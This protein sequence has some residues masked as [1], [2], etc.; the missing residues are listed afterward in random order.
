[1]SEF[2]RIILN[3]IEHYGG[4]R[5]HNTLDDINSQF[6]KGKIKLFIKKVKCT[7]DPAMVY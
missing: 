6:L 2:F 7:F 4:E 3:W 1:M 5:G